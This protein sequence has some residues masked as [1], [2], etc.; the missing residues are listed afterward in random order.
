[1]PVASKVALASPLD[2]PD[3]SP[4][5]TNVETFGAMSRDSRIN[6]SQAHN[7]MHRYEL[8]PAAAQPQNPTASYNVRTPHPAPSQKWCSTLTSPRSIV[9]SKNPGDGA[10]GGRASGGHP[11]SGK[12]GW[13]WTAAGKPTQRARARSNKYVGRSS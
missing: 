2:G 5:A 10:R 9:I 6:D 8:I 3:Q 4:P 1:M 11:R 7:R 12:A 13:G